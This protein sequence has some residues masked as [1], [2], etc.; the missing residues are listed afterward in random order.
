MVGHEILAQGVNLTG[1][2]SKQ[3]VILQMNDDDFPARFLQD[4]ASEST[5]KISSATLVDTQSQPLF[6]PVQRL[7]TV[8]MVD[9][10]CDSLSNPPVDPKRI[11]SAGLVVRRVYR[12]KTGHKTIDEFDTLSAWV[13][14][15]QG[16]YSWTK[17]SSHQENLDPDPTQR[18]Q[19]KSGQAALDQQLAALTLATAN[20]ESTT[21][22]FAAP[23]AT[24]E[25]LNKTVFYAVIPTASSEMSDTP[26]AQPPQFDTQGLINSL[27]GMLRA[28]QGPTS[29]V[30]PLQDATIDYHWMSDDFLY[31][32]YPPSA[33]TSSQPPQTN[34]LVAP[35]QVFTTALRM[36]HTV[37]NAFNGTNEGDAILSV[38]NGCSVTF[39]D[40]TTKKMGDFYMSA[41]EVLLDYNAYPN[42]AVQGTIR[43][44]GSV[45]WTAAGTASWKKSHAYT[46]GQ[47]I[48]DAN[49]NI[50]IVQTGG[51]SGVNAPYWSLNVGQTTQ[52]GGVLWN[53][54]GSSVWLPD[55]TYNT[56]QAI[57]DSTGSI[58]IATAGGVSALSPP[59]WLTAPTLTMPHSWEWLDSCDQSELIS[60][61]IAALNAATKPGSNV[62][63]P[64]GRFQ[65]STRYYKLRMFF[66]VKPESGTCPPTLVWS[67]YSDSFQIAPW[68]ATGPRPHPPIPLPDPTSTFLQ[69]AKPNCSFLVP[70][71]LMNAMQGT[72]MSGLMSGAGGAGPSSLSWLCGFNIPL[73]TICAFF[74]LNIFL[75]LLNIVF[76]WL[77]MIKICIPFPSPSSADEGSP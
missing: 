52:D 30:V 34:P 77:P 55:T 42:P 29:P 12:K 39:A 31:A 6:Q 17:L 1:L 25:A 67:Q 36:L 73:I 51:T 5:P 53:N 69:N 71:S 48:L 60:A 61:L 16:Q 49:G 63:S 20:T 21:P 18:P 70:G 2:Q 9:L 50:Q 46:V 64:Q 75:M 13:H 74:V 68:H 66:R 3:P 24:C 47:A 62:L 15:P 4:L 38:L 27:P 22:A 8:A 44:D 32:M 45:T 43:I 11:V 28:V 10:S 41:K 59:N 57:L 76:F 54:L 65:D 56:G 26:P 72:S 7:L 23:P 19:L 33:P 58:Q 37:F 35:F 40:T 14:N